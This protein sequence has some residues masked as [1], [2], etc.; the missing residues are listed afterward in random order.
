MLFSDFIS[1][2][3]QYERDGPWDHVTLPEGS[4][5]PVRRNRVYVQSHRDKSDNSSD[6]LHA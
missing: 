5:A 1:Q 2:S 4:T 3:R 6:L